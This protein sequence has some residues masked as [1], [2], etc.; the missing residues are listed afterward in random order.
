MTRLLFIIT[1][2]A[3]IVLI[4][5]S[6]IILPSRVAIHFGLYGMP[7]NWAPSYIHALISLGLDTLLFCAMFYSPRLIFIFPKKWINLPHK[8]YWLTEGNIPRTRSLVSSLMWEFGIAL[9]IFLFVAGLFTIHANLSVPVKL[10][11]NLFLA[12]DEL[13]IFYWVII[14]YD[15]CSASCFS[16]YFHRDSVVY[17]SFVLEYEYNISVRNVLLEKVS[18]NDLGFSCSELGYTPSNRLYLNSLHVIAQL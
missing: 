2:I 10:N 9:F 8:D 1:F 16:L 3:N 14:A 5:I 6:L 11:E 13:H 17:P 7:D 4:I 12:F 18:Q 15:P